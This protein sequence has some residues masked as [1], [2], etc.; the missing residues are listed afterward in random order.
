MANDA[1]L[2]EVD[3][4][5]FEI[6]L[7]HEQA[8]LRGQ[9]SELGFGADGGL[10]YDAN[11]ADSSQ[12]NAERGEAEPWPVSCATPSSRW[13]MPSSASMRVPTDVACAAV[14]RSDGTSRGDARSAALHDLRFG[15]LKR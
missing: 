14:A 11:F 15:P 3:T 12:V 7:A 5:Q 4:A 9:L 2:S 8:D 1:P 6:M 13:R 10:N